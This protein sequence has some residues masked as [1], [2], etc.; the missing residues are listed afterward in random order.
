MDKVLLTNA[1]RQLHGSI[2][3]APNVAYERAVRQFNALLNTAKS[4]FPSRPDIV[5]IEGFDEP[6]YVNAQELMDVTGRLKGALELQ[7]PGSL[8]DLVAEIRLPA[9]APAELSA[10]LQEFCNAIGLNLRK[11]ALLLSGAIAEALLLLRHGDKSEKGPGLASLVKEARDK[12]LFGSDTLRQLET[13]VDYRD[14]IHVR[15]GPRNRI[16]IND[17][18]VQHAAMALRLLCG[19]L[20][21][22][23]VRF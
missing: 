2:M 9:D 10:D 23:S 12:R 21:D 7:T 14:L 16:E 1:V 17:A 6:R 11:S 18:R 8:G 4:L 19:E 15:A 3:P 13:L 5:A 22:T 20:E